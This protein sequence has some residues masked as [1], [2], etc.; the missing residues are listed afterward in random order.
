MWILA[1]LHKLFSLKYVYKIRMEKV[2]A[3]I[4]PLI[5]YISFIFEKLEGNISLSFLR[6][7]CSPKLFRNFF[8]IDRKL[9]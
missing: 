7:L 6:R 1:D 4:G 5:H 8:E 9:N 3:F 2:K